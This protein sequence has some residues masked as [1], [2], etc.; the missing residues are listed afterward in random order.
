MKGIIFIAVIVI[1]LIKNTSFCI[2]TE[3]G[4]IR[5][6]NTLP[7][8]GY[9][10]GN[11]QYTENDFIFMKETLSKV[12]STNQAY[13]ELIK[14]SWKYLSKNDI[15][16]A[17][18]RAN[19]AWLFKQDDFEVYM[20]FGILTRTYSDHFK[21]MEKVKYLDESLFYQNIACR[22]NPTNGGP[23]LDIAMVNQK[24]YL[25]YPREKLTL[26]LS[27]QLIVS[28]ESNFVQA[29]KYLKDDMR[30]G[31]L[32]YYWL[33]FSFLRQD[34]KLCRQLYIKA[35]QYKDYVNLKALESIKEKLDEF[36]L[37]NK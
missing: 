8:Y 22:L 33:V 7:M 36:D 14:L 35:C 1:L 25:S 18:K 26:E 34:Y 30:K 2:N 27:N 24:I 5:S 32:Y 13:Q 12:S 31:M 29:E 9:T 28:A 19:Q 15:A 17:I 23:N 21:D 16:T 3:S 10:N 37:E 4:D 11:Y 6:W 20:L